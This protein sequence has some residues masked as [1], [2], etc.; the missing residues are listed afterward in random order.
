MAA[1]LA[2]IEVIEEENLADNAYEWEY[3]REGRMEF[4]EKISRHRRCSWH[5]INAG[6]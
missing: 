1:A 3:I 6:L 2:T 4:A 5:G